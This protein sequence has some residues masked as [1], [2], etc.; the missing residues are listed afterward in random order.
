MIEART[1]K[2]VKIDEPGIEVMSFDEDETV[3]LQVDDYWRDQLDL[4]MD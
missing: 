3:V 4:P 2:I 1:E